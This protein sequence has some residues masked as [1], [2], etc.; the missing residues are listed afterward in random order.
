VGCIY[1]ITCATF[2]CPRSPVALLRAPTMHGNQVHREN[3]TSVFDNSPI[4]LAEDMRRAGRGY[5]MYSWC[6]C[7][8]VHDLPP[9]EC[10][11]RRALQCPSPRLALCGPP[12]IEPHRRVPAEEQVMC[13]TLPVVRSSLDCHCANHDSRSVSVP[14]RSIQRSHQKL[15]FAVRP[16][17][18]GRPRLQVRTFHQI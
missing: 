15:A 5:G 11:I 12:R 10:S 13:C 2:G 7:N 1:R 4:I 6:Q 8:I 9:G 17:T 3:P 16:L 18:N 14:T